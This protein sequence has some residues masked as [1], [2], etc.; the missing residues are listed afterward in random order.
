[1]FMML[2]VLI[3]PAMI[4]FIILAKVVST[5]LCVLNALAIINFRLLAVL[6]KY[7]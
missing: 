3:T 7:K 2:Y 6:C 4:L 5:V 1:M